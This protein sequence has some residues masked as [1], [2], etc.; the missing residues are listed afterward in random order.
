MRKVSPALFGIAALSFLL[1]FLTF[2]CN[3]S[4]EDLGLPGAD[5]TMTITGID[6]A[7]GIRSFAFN[8]PEA[9]A[10][11]AF[12]GDAVSPLVLAALSLSFAGIGTVWVRRRH[13]LWD[14]AHA[15][16]AALG[17]AALILTRLNARASGGIE[18]DAEWI[19]RWRYGWWVAVVAL[20]LA[21]VFNLA[22][23]IRSGVARQEPTEG[24]L[25]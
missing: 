6:L 2:E 18:D 12:A 1:P 11:Q 15:T 7:L 23:V 4:G 9:E 10:T 21:G 20:A 24:A 17:A 3:A 16:G 19:L 8:H 22:L 14:A 25:P 13:W 5:I